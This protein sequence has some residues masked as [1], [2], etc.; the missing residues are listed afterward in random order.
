MTETCVVCCQRDA[1]EFCQPC[2]HCLLCKECSLTMRGQRTKAVAGK[3]MICARKIEKIISDNQPD[4]DFD[5]VKPPEPKTHEKCSDCLNEACEFC[6]NRTLHR[7]IFTAPLVEEM[8]NECKTPG[9][10]WRSARCN[11]FEGV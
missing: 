6:G 5:A 8:W 4:I 11:T 10:P 7:E 1:T 9:C 2:E 3:C